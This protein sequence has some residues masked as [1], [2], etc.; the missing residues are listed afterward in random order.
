TLGLERARA[1]ALRRK[2]TDA[3]HYPGF[4]LLAAGG[5]LI[6]FVMFVLPQFSAVLRDFNAKTDPMIE[7]F[8]GLSDLL[9]NHGIELGILIV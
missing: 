6:F 5:V 8:L 3:L 2:V 9:R 1:E 7:F 4:V